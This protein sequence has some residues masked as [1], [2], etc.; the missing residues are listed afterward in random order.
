M[1][2][3]ERNQSR[4]RRR[5]VVTGLGAIS[6]LGPSAEELWDRLLAG[7]SGIRTAEN[8]DPTIIN[9]TIRGDVDDETIPNRFLEG[10]T[11]RNTSRFARLAVEA[12]GEALIDA[13]LI[14][15]ETYEPTTSLEPAGAV[16]GTCGA[17][18]HDD[19]LDAWES[20]KGRGVRG[21]PIHL[22]VSFPHNLAGYGV[23]SRF[24]MGG[25]SLTLT[26][27]CATGAQAIGEAFEEVRDG[28]APIM[29]GGATESTHHPMYAAGFAVMRALVTDSNDDPAAGSRP[30]DASRAGFVLGEGA[31]MLVLEDLEHALNRD[32][33]IYA[34]VLG[35]GTSNDAY[36]PI[37]P[38]P[39]GRGG[40]RAMHTALYDA[41]VAPEE[42]DHI[43]AHAAS[44]PAGDLAES[45]AIR[46][47]YGE[48]APS[49]PV[50][51]M[52]GALG[53]CM[54]AAGALETIAAVRTI[55]DQ[56]IPPTRNYQN[57]DEAIGL[58][59]VHGAPR[60]ADV[61]IVAKHAFGLGGQNAC[62]ILGRYDESREA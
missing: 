32:A 52:K 35:F 30:F 27:A 47:I 6:S 9:C 4:P 29:I 33:R 58:D 18:V 11:L 12:A 10:K 26:T 15:C 22:H 23:Q 59:I 24:G 38:L 56:T 7:E 55:S 61:G 41:G 5:V 40:A 17:G 14:D 8:L 57:P 45:E 43:N 13:G 34:E 60:N 19:F 54:G 51:S 42:V 62:L 44:T 49:I 1:T 46:L 16:I 48:R 25:P 31:A 2:R 21:V 37:A 28:K 39:D 53:H 50:T 36:H 20:Y 3:Y